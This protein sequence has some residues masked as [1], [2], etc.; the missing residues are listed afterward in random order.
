MNTKHQTYYGKNNFKKINLNERNKTSRS[1]Q[2]MKRKLIFNA[3]RIKSFNNNDNDNDKDNNIVIDHS[4]IPRSNV[5][6]ILVK[7]YQKD[8][9]NSKEINK[10]VIPLRNKICEYQTKNDIISKEIMELRSETKKFLNRYKMIGLLKPKNN[11]QLLKLGLS[12]ETINDINSKGYRI[13]EILNK[14]NIFDKSLLLNKFSENYAKNVIVTKNPELVNDINYITKFS[15]SLSE[16]RNN[17]LL[18]HTDYSIPY[19][20]SKKRQSIYNHDLNKY[21]FNFKKVSIFQLINEFNNINNDLKMIEHKKFLKKK[22]KEKIKQK[23]S[24]KSNILN[25][26]Q[27]LISLEGNNHGIKEEK[28]KVLKMINKFK[29]E[30][31]LRRISLQEIPFQKFYL[32]TS[33]QTSDNQSNN[34]TSLS[35]LK[36][37]RRKTFF[38]KRISALSSKDMLNDSSRLSLNISNILNKSKQNQDEFKNRRRNLNSFRIAN[39]DINSFKYLSPNNSINNKDILEYESSKEYTKLINKTQ[40]GKIIERLK[41][42]KSRIEEYKNNKYN[43]IQ[44]LYNKLKTKKYNEYKN[45]LDNY[46]KTYRGIKINEPNY[47][48]GSQIYSVIN[49]FIKK[50]NQY[51]LPNEMNKIRYR[52]NIFSHKK[53]KKYQEILKLNNK[54]ENLI[55]DYTEDL[56]DL[57]NDIK[58]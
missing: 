2:N 56:L 43:T 26:K 46:L 17:N 51:N 11:S 55:Y 24:I 21:D 12:Q 32:K 28:N 29:K 40:E 49:E 42:R 3:T 13:N 36:L 45:D 53:S 9:S 20:Q 33:I 19:Q 15:K 1:N 57:N 18:T 34:R 38:N 52:N 8:K 35:N 25:S 54:I 48:K 39:N 7:Y 6:K 10:E 27:M 22:K 5:L 44:K 50:S 30:N 58:I 31:L 23:T 14:T 41:R 37:S 4:Y 16:R 47:E